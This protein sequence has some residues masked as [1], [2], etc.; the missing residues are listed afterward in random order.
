MRFKGLARLLRPCKDGNNETVRM[1]WVLTWFPSEDKLS[2]VV[3]AS[4]GT[5]V[6]VFFIP[7]DV[8][9]EIRK[10]RGLFRRIVKK[11]GIRSLA[12]WLI[13]LEHVDKFL[14][15]TRKVKEQW[16]RAKS[17][18]KTFIED[19]ASFSDSWVVLDR[20]VR[21]GIDPDVVRA[22]AKELMSE[23]PVI[24]VIPLDIPRCRIEELLTGP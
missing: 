4:E 16:D 21:Y 11:Y 6:K 8:E 15:E 17:L 19:P 2:K 7:K 22:K 24:E 23:E 14:V 3:K 20:Y 13:P 1:Y 5:Q 9:L 12:G 18:I 10:V